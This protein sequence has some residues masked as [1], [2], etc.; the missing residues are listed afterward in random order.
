[1]LRRF[2]FVYADADILDHA[3]LM[4]LPPAARLSHCYTPMP[5]PRR[6]AADVSTSEL[7]QNTPLR[8]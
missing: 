5:M 3:V 1:M 2:V 7:E 4:F 8:H 6:I